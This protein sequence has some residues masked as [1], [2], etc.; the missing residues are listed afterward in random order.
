MTAIADLDGAVLATRLEAQNSKSLGHDH[1]LLAIEGRGDTLKESQSLDGSSTPGGFV[2]Q[3]A[4]NG[5]EEDFGG[6]TVMEGA[7]L[8]GVHNMAF[9][10]E[11]VVAKLEHER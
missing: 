5:L 7:R 1:S 3:H 10:K 2:R 9:V 8:L 6:G 11:V 4:T